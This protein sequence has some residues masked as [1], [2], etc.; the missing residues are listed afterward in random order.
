[1][2]F[3][4]LYDF[5]GKPHT[6]KNTLRTPTPAWGYVMYFYEFGWGFPLKSNKFTK[7]IFL[8][9]LCEPAWGYA[10]NFYQFGLGFPLKSYKFTK[11]NFLLDL[12]EPAWAYVVLVGLACVFL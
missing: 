12:C 9:D 7:P 3:V 10:M 8:L 6:H 1:M 2:G 11:T 4:N 5:R